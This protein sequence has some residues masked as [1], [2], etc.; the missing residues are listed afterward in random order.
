MYVFKRKQWDFH[1][2]SIF[3][4]VYIW[5]NVNDSG[6]ILNDLVQRIKYRYMYKTGFYS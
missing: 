6:V 5:I 1:K 3:E 4:Y 2:L